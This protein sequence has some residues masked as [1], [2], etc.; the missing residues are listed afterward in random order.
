[1]AK[2][3]QEGKL[4]TSPITDTSVNKLIQYYADNKDYFLITDSEDSVAFG[5]RNGYEENG[6]QR[7]VWTLHIY[8]P[9]FIKEHKMMGPVEHIRW[10]I[11]CTTKIYHMTYYSNYESD[12]S[13]IDFVNY[14]EYDNTMNEPIVPGTFV[15]RIYDAACTSGAVNTY[16]VIRDH[17]IGGE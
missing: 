8:K 16:K 7:W 9:S 12:G 11:D 13:V 17:G 4:P 15:E 3:K 1:M 6:A 2:E 5:N 10:Y 14:E